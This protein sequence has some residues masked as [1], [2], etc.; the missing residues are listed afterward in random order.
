MLRSSLKE[1]ASPAE[2]E[3]ALVS[4]GMIPTA[5]PQDLTLEKFSRL[6]ELLC[7]INSI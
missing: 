3:K 5:R 7:P 4:I 2:I 6:T 1:V